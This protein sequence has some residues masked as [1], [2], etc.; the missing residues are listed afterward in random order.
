M[1]EKI[2][3]KHNLNSYILPYLILSFPGS[4]DNSAKKLGHFLN[5]YKIRTY[6]YQ[7]F[8]P[9]P[10]TMSTAMFFAKK[11]ADGKNLNII[12][13]SVINTSQRD[14]LKKLLTKH[15]IRPEN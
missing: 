14:I 2:K 15:F 11:S 3:K 1:F 12:S 4:S 10:Q 5:Q 9:V 13:P 8:T 6:Q 7:D